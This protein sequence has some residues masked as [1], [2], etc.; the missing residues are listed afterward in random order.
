[1]ADVEKGQNQPTPLATPDITRRSDEYSKEKKSE[2]AKLDTLSMHSVEKQE[3]FV[4]TKQVR[5]SSEEDSKP[6]N[7][8]YPRLRPFILAG[9]ALLIL[10]WWISATIL[11]ATRHR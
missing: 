4:K 3:G 5:E 2:D 6:H 10:G 9:L 8:L 7:P 1:M 11:P